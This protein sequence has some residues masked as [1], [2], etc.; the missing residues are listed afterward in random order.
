MINIAGRVLLLL[1]L[2]YCTV[3]YSTTL[4]CIT[5]YTHPFIVVHSEYPSPKMARGRQDHT[6]LSLFSVIFLKKHGWM[7]K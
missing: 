6:A 3:Q 1:L 4:C 2:L 5:V 7:K